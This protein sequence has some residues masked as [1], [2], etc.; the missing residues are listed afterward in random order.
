MRVHDFEIK[1]LGKIAPYGVDDIAA[2]EGWI[3]VEIDADT[4]AFAVESIRRWRQRLGNACYPEAQRLTIM[5]PGS[6]SGNASC[7]VSPTR[8]VV[9]HH[10]PGTSSR[11]DDWRGRLRS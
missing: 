1:G 11:V 9:T 3:N 4:A 5:A 10:P 8:P 2:N 7:S 6:A